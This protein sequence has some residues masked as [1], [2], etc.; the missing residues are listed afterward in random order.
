MKIT[1]TAVETADTYATAVI[2]TGT[3]EAGHPVRVAVNRGKVADEIVV[4]LER[5]DSVVTIIEEWQLLDE[6]AAGPT[7]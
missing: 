6:R 7:D 4:A 2:F 5:E 1:V 3:D